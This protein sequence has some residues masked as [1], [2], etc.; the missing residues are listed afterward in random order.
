MKYG[1]RTKILGG[2]GLVLAL[3]IVAGGFSIYALGNV[4][5][6]AQGLYEDQTVPA[7]EMAEAAVLLESANTNLERALFAESSAEAGEYLEVAA[8]QRAEFSALLV[9]YRTHQEELGDQVALDLFGEFEAS[10][11]PYAASIP[12]IEEAV[13]AG[14][15]DEAREL[16]E[17][18]GIDGAIEAHD[19]VVDHHVELAAETNEHI[20]AEYVQERTIV[21]V[22]IGL[23]LFASAGIALYLSRSIVNGVERVRNTMEHLSR[24]GLVNLQQAMQSVAEGNLRARAVVDTPDVNVNTSDEI[25]EMANGVNDMLLRARQ[26]GEAYEAMRGQLGA[27][28]RGVRESSVQFATAAN[29]LAGVADQTGEASNQVAYSIT[30]IAHGAQSQSED[31][32]LAST[33]VQGIGESMLVVQDSTESLGVSMQG[34]QRAV[35]HSADVVNQLGER[36]SQVGSIVNTI[37]DIASQT[38]LLA[39][40]AAIEAARAGEHGKGFAV[41]AEEVRKLA[42]QS[43]AATKEIGTLLDQVRAGIEQAVQ[44]M[45]ITSHQQDDFASDDGVIPIGQ[46]LNAA[47][48]ELSGIEQRTNEVGMAVEQVVASMQQIDATSETAMSMSE[49]VS[50]ASEETS[51]QV[52]ELVANS[53]HIATMA[54]S[55]R[56]Q[57]EQF[58]IDDASVSAMRKAANGEREYERAA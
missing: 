21:M 22:L 50:A 11:A 48:R 16:H 10:Y 43:A 2:F 42:E 24:N 26:T 18:A 38:N 15:L 19:A 35:E 33:S 47:N 31:I 17:E 51:A 49:D 44:T 25:G 30:N 55:L 6:E 41:V 7:I 23:A 14:E 13:F 40:N 54:E 4:T 37:D 3:F 45:D 12:G 39:L 56:E 46:A 8:E 1:I 20:H 29:D 52:Q 53:Q 27:L 32:R 36:S 58:Q 57:V 5:G 28:I 9:T 34:V